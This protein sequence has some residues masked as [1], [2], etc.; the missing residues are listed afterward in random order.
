MV[1]LGDVLRQVMLDGTFVE[2]GHYEGK[3]LSPPDVGFC[4]WR[5][6]HTRSVCSLQEGV[7][8]TSLDGTDTS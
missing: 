4:T 5:S 6:V 3:N 8:K 2:F 7:R 1:R